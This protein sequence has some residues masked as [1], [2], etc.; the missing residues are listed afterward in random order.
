MVS[1]LW[2]SS[3]HQRV[4]GSWVFVLT[5]VFGTQAVSAPGETTQDSAA[6]P[7]IVILYADDMGWGDTGAYGHPYIK[8][9]SLDRLANEGQ[10]W[11]DFYVPAPVCSP[12]RAALLTGRHPVRSGLYG[13][14]S[15][16][17]LSLIHI[18]EPT[19]PY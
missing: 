5:Y 10:R 12:S 3:R 1:R 11:T 4:F 2:R 8:T 17:L 6:R 13:V 7:N 18:S 16:V 15:P 9:P 19:R 14:G